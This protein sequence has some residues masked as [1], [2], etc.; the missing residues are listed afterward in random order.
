MP[1]RTSDVARWADG[2]L[3]W[4]HDSATLFR[5]GRGFEASTDDHYPGGPNPDGRACRDPPLDADGVPPP[6]RGWDLAGERPFKCRIC[7]RAFTTK[8]NLKTHMGVHRNK[9]HPTPARVNDSLLINIPHHHKARQLSAVEPPSG[10]VRQ[11]P[12]CQKQF[13][14]TPSLQEHIHQHTRNLTE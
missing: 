8:G 10:V 9:H 4:P 14:S 7:Q 3:S 12:I 5:P 11:C 6:A 1:S 2:G 13:T